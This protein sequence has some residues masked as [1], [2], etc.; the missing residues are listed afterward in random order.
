ML[1]TEPAADRAALHGQFAADYDQLT[2]AYHCCAAEVLFGLVYEYTRPG[3]CLLDLGIGTGLS[4]APFVQAGLAVW[5]VDVSPDMLAVCRAKNLA[6][7]LRVADL[8]AQPWPYAPQSFEQVL[9]CGLLHFFGDL[10]AVFRSVARVLRPGGYF[11]FALKRPS[12]A[13]SVEVISDTLPASTWA[14]K[15]V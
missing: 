12:M 11:T 2:Q 4:A 7:D 6:V 10:D 15:T 5:G 1:T 8:A 14:R 9:A 3:Q 13:S